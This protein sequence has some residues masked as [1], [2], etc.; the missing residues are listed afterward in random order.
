MKRP[1]RKLRRILYTTNLYLLLGICKYL[2][3]S[4]LRIR[5]KKK[6]GPRGP[7]LVPLRPLPL[8]AIIQQIFVSVQRITNYLY[9]GQNVF[10]ARFPRVAATVAV[11]AGISYFAHQ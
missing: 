4:F 1:G 2:L 8:A 5:K 11:L 3:C 7:V 6:K 9:F 10:F